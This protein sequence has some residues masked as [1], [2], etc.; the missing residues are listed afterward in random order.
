MTNVDEKDIMET[1]QQSDVL[2]SG[3]ATSMPPP[4]N[5]VDVTGRKR[6]GRKSSLSTSS[7][8][9]ETS[10][11]APSTRGKRH[12]STSGATTDDDNEEDDVPLTKLI[13]ARLS[14]LESKMKAKDTQIKQLETQIKKNKEEADRKES[15]LRAEL[16]AAHEKLTKRTEQLEACG[17][18]SSAVP[19]DTGNV[20]L[21]SARISAM[22]RQDMVVPPPSTLEVKITNAILS[23]QEER[24]KRKC[25]VI[26]FGVH[27]RVHKSDEETTKEKDRAITALL[28]TLGVDGS[29]VAHSRRFRQHSNTSGHPPPIMI[30]MVDTVARDELLRAA[31]K[32]RDIVFINPDMTAKQRAEAKESRDLR[33]AER[34]R[35]ASNTKSSSAAKH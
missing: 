34:E 16:A 1:S 27:V 12:K 22:K 30:T 21:S 11:I 25:N 9:L 15:I 2:V 26:V 24:E 6:A 8:N 32:L 31:R 17:T 13:L 4:P 7:T 3:A 14:D 28:D 19:L 18:T 35:A 29:K 33:R 5:P 23:E 20:W 10:S